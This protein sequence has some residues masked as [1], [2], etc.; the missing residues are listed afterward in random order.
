MQEY[1]DWEILSPVKGLHR[2]GTLSQ[3]S[4]CRN[5]G[6]RA[7]DLQTRSAKIKMANFV[8]R[9][10]DTGERENFEEFATAMS[11]KIMYVKFVILSKTV[12]YKYIIKRKKL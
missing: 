9:W 1:G 8:G 12:I 2:P 7:F 3:I 4:P 11:K 5:L 10:E 6:L